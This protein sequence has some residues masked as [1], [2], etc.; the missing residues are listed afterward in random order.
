M[1]VRLRLRKTKRDEEARK[2]LD[3]LGDFNTRCGFDQHS[4]NLAG[5][6]KQWRMTIKRHN[7]PWDHASNFNP[8]ITFKTVEDMHA[9]IA[10]FFQSLN[11]FSMAPSSL[12][13]IAENIMRKRANMF[14]SY[15]KW[16]MENQSNVISYFDKWVHDGC[17]FGTAVGY[18]PWVKLIRNM[19]TEFY[20]PDEAKQA[21]NITDRTLIQIALGPRLKKGPTRISNDRY[22]I[23]FIDDDGEEKDASAMLDRDHP[24]KPQG[25]PVLLVERDVIYYN[26]PQPRSL[27]LWNVFVPTDVRDLQ[28]ARRFWIRDWI[29]KNDL[30]GNWDRGIF[31]TMTQAEYTLL[32]DIIAKSE[33]GPT[34]GPHDKVDSYRDTELPKSLLESRNDM[35]EVFY[36]YCYEDTDGDGVPESIIRCVTNTRYPML[37]M[38]QRLEYL[39]PHGR[40]PFSDWHFLPIGDRYYGMGIPEILQGI[41]RE[42]NAFYQARNDAVE[43][44]S[45]PAGMYA[46]FSGLS[47]ESIQIKPG[48]L[49]KVNDPSRAYKPFEW[50]ANPDLLWREQAGSE[51]HAER[52]IGATDM[53][54]GRGPTRPNAPRTLGGTAIMVRQQQL[55][56]DVILRRAIYGTTEV[57]GGV[58]EFLH[59]YRELCAAFMPEETEF[60]VLGSDEVRKISRSDI[61]GRFDF[62][63]DFGEGVNNP[64]LRMQN[65]QFRYQQAMGNP[66]IQRAPMALYEITVDFLEA[67]GMKNARRHLPPPAEGMSHPPMTQGDEFAIMSKGMYIDVLPADNHE[68]HLTEIAMLSQDVERMAMMFGERKFELVHRHAEEHMK[69]YQMMMSGGGQQLGGGAPGG[70][71]PG[72]AGQLDP[73]SGIGSGPAPNFPQQEPE[74]ELGAMP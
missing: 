52:A 65:S 28:S 32:S 67:T 68:E 18:L 42:G 46:A 63:F 59:Q 36:E 22:R 37:L 11:F 24:Y 21:D 4:E 8:P 39:Y 41:Q 60:R 38:R 1:S 73:R 54:L 15:V 27:P 16:S 61:Q 55:R 57:G 14:E 5:F 53:G 69:Y 33:G 29:D 19:R 23:T 31:N 2:C 72:G 26:A 58:K 50:A 13:D 17:L 74:A 7:P 6:D 66:L 70:A 64:Q 25:E 56:T 30:R 3:D 48:T 62:V 45:K 35:I 9:I 12:Q 71:Q 20:L 44:M 43:I 47:P 49:V 40:R 34:V 10:G 51:L